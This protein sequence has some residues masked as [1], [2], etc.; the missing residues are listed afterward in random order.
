VRRGA[1]GLPRDSVV[2]VTQVPTLDRALLFERVRTPA[3]GDVASVDEGL[4]LS[5]GS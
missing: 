5:L 3:A 1:A 4:R 2:N